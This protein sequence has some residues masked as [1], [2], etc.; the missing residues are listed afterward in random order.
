MATTTSYDENKP[1]G[2]GVVA[3]A[4]TGSHDENPITVTTV[5]EL[6]S[7]LKSD[8]KK[9]IYVKN[10]ITFNKQLS[11]NGAHDK[12]IY[13]LPGSVLS[14]PTHSDNRDES[15]ILMLKN[16]Q[17]IILR[18]LTFKGAG[19]YD[20]DG[21]D[22][23]TLQKCQHIWVDHCD[24]QDGVDG[25]L[26]CQHGSDLIC[27]SWCRFH[28]LLAPWSG[29]SGGANDHRYTNLIGSSDKNAA[30]DEGHLRITYTNCWWDEG[31]RERMPRIRFGQV[32]IVNCLYSSTVANYCVGTG[33]RCNAYVE[34]C[35]FINQKHPWKNYA[36]SGSYTD[37]NITVTDCVGAKDEQSHSGDIDY[38]NPYAVSDYTLTAYGKELVETVVKEGAGATLPIAE[39]QKYTT[40]LTSAATSLTS[41]TDYYSLSG[42]KADTQTRGICIGVGKDAAGKP[43]TKKFYR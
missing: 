16:C 29:G 24:F 10:T 8:D 38:F 9:T 37:Y 36:T 5:E 22:N 15:G 19:A 43:I 13:G 14:N 35:A 42:A 11:I 23:L 26:D 28:Y 31:C 21:N 4:I 2:W 40:A 7:A 18:N 6:A 30:E 17:N 12:T 20:I 33:Y 32:H 25:N 3:S 34:K 39:G 1:V 27:I 41:V